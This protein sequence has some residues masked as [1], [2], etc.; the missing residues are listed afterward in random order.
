M[1]VI[2]QLLPY[3]QVTLAV[4]LCIGILI[5]QTAAGLGG[6]L[7]DSFTSSHHT[8]RG[9]EKFAFNTTVILAIAF[10]LSAFLALIIK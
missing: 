2:S 7:G 1:Q 5:Q 10:A 8:R 4:L 3:I 6:A 9:F